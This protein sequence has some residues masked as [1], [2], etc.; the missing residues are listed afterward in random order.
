LPRNLLDRGS[1]GVEDQRHRLF[2]HPSHRHVFLQS[3][4][5]QCKY[6]STKSMEIQ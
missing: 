6:Y 5:L 4:S 1:F 3:S 2:R